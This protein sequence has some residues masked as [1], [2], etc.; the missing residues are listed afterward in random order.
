MLDQ[1]VSGKGTGDAEETQDSTQNA[2][3]NDD[4]TMRMEY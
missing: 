3:V 4:G 1:F 2:L